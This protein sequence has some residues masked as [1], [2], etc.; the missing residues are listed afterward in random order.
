[1]NRK[2][3]LAAAIA[4]A[5]STAIVASAIT[6]VFAQE[7]NTHP[8]TSETQYPA[9]DKDLIAVSE[10]ALLAMRD[11]RAARLAIFNGL[12]KKARTYTDAAAARMAAAL[13]DVARYALDIKQPLKGGEAYVPFDAS[14]AVVETGMLGEE[15][16]QHVSKANEHLHKGETK[17]AVEVLKLGEIDVVLTTRLVPLKAAEQGIQNAVKLV[18]EGKYYEANIA[19]KAV[20][21]A[22]L[23]ETFGIDAVPKVK[24]H[25]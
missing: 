5:L 19:L 8:A 10:D 23:V 25:S 6:P 12:P 21:D 20:E 4:V 11:V 22:V 3:R 9:A 18:S 15:K 7:G 2:T 14:L 16:M 17:K 13:K 1:M 24:G